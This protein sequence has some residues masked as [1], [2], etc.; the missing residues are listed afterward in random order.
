MVDLQKIFACGAFG[1]SFSKKDHTRKIQIVSLS[2]T[3]KNEVFSARRRRKIFR[4]QE[5]P[6]IPPP[7][8]FPG[9][10]TTGGV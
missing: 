5:V 2:E 4:I 6:V 9:S 3:L 10:G 1:V 7:L 8:V